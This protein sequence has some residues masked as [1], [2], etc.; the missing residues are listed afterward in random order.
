MHIKKKLLFSALG[1]VSIAGLL[2]V[3]GSG[4]R[5]TSLGALPEKRADNSSDA[6]TVP[7]IVPRIASLERTT[8]QPAVVHANFEA[9]IYAKVAGYLKELRVDIGQKVRKDEVLGVIWVPEM[10]RNVETQEKTVEHL[11]AEEKR[12]QAGL[13]LAKANL[14]SSKVA[15][16]QAEA[17]I[18]RTQGQLAA[19]SAEFKRVE[20][21]V[22]SNVVDSRVRDETRYRRESSRGGA[23]G[24]DAAVRLAK[25]QV[26]VAEA[27][28]EAAQGDLDVARA[29]T[30]VARN[31]LEELKVMNAY[32]FL[33]APFDGVITERFVEPGDLV[34]SVSSSSEAP[35]RPLFTV[36]QV[37]VVRA[38]VTV[39]E[40]DAPGVQLGKA[41]TLSLQA[42]PGRLF[43]GHVM[44]TSGSLDQSTRTLLV[45]V[46]LPNPK[47]EILPG[48]YGEA[49]ISLEERKDAVILPAKTVHRDE[50]GRGFVYVVND[51]GIVHKTAVTTGLDNG[52]DLEIRGPLKGGERI[53]DATVASL[54]DGQKVTAQQ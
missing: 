39:P 29:V 22:A 51:E 54:K 32:A 10:D 8:T 1:V 12:A 53:A 52:I 16:A 28:I 38:R 37:D 41:V 5:N 2:I 27:K 36:A 47:G 20:D 3:A 7:I 40:R 31:K 4:W 19:D 25:A 42:M 15:V 44:R 17:D 9:K 48:M 18:I 30:S 13:A 43:H 33:R 14:A 26:G 49:T 50:E 21:L 46:D 6:T 24:A 11:V 35:R 45:E 23:A 34:R